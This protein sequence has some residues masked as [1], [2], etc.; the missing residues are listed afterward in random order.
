MKWQSENGLLDDHWD[1]WFEGLTLERHENVDS[2]QDCTLII[3]PMA[4]QPALHEL[5]AKTRDLNISLISVRKI[6]PKEPS[7]N[8]VDQDDV[9]T[10]PSLTDTQ[11]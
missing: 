1:Q 6:D 4:D 11:E 2:G 10:E 3:G 5:L 7:G 8:G 9:N